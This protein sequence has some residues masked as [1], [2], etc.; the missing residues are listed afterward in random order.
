M[1]RILDDVSFSIRSF[2]FAGGFSVTS[3]ASFPSI[4]P[5]SVWLSVISSRE[6]HPLVIPELS[7]L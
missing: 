7:Q 5:V 2:V 3:N 6:N 1:A 4:V